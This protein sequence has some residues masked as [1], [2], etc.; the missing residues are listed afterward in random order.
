MP[1]PEC[2]VAEAATLD[3]A[4]IVEDTGSYR[5]T[6]DMDTEHVFMSMCLCMMLG[7]NTHPFGY[8]WLAHVVCR[9][10]VIT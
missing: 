2:L 7:M 10:R 1:P 8:M 6:V 3:G 4:V 5:C 9:W